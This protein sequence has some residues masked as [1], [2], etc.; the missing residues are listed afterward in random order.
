M[1]KGLGAEP[2]GKASPLS[3]SAAGFRL[4]GMGGTEEAS[5]RDPR[6]GGEDE[7]PIHASKVEWLLSSVGADPDDWNS[8]GQDL[9]FLDLEAIQDAEGRA[10]AG[11][12]VR[13]DGFE[14][15]LKR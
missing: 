7:L 2:D 9:G 5:A 8:H 15:G 13:Q 12:E 1:G 4:H 11:S 3:F 10:G 6:E 14:T